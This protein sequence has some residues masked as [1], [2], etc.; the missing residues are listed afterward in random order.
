MLWCYWLKRKT[1][2]DHGIRF[3]EEARWF[4]DADFLLRLAAKGATVSVSRHCIYD[5]FIREASAMRSSPIEARH[6]CS[7]MLGCNMLAFAKTVENETIRQSL[8]RITA[9]SIAW[10]IRE[11]ADTY[12]KD[13]Y[14]YARRRTAFPL[15]LGGSAKQ[16][17]QI[18]VLNI[19]FNIYRA[20]CRVLK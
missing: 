13:L 16:K 19:G 5:Y 15:A 10:C 7:V 3:C 1:I 11:A 14:T 17:L 6:R 12:A 8:R 20:F 9:V 18:A 2:T 4:E